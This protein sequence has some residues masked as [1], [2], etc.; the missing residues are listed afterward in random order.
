MK[1]IVCKICYNT[2]PLISTSKFDGEYYCKDQCLKEAIELKEYN[3]CKKSHIYKLI[4]SMGLTIHNES[5]VNIITTIRKHY[6]L[7]RFK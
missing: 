7:H 5:I 1:Q 4:E 6:L 3:N 2:V